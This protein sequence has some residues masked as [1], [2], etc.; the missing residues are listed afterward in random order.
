VSKRPFVLFQ[1]PTEFYGLSWVFATPEKLKGAS[2][3]TLGCTY[4]LK[5]SLVDDAGA[6]LMFTATESELSFDLDSKRGY[7]TVLV[8]LYAENEERV[9]ASVA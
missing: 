5:L 7:F 9:F 2:V 1:A 4:P 6:Y 8:F 3:F